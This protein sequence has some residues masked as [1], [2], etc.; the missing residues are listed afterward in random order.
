MSTN[1]HNLKSILSV[2]AI[3]AFFVGAWMAADALAFKRTFSGFW[4]AIYLA[5]LFAAISL[6]LLICSQKRLSIAGAALAVVIAVLNLPTI[7][8]MFP[9]RHTVQPGSFT[10]ATVADVLHHIAES[11][12]DTMPYW[13]FHVSD[14]Q[15]ACTPVNMAIP[16]NASLGE[17]LNT[18]MAQAEATYTWTWHKNYGNESLPLCASFLV[19]RDSSRELADYELTI[20]RYGIY[21][22]E[23]VNK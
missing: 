4:T 12:H 21:G 19:S 1:T 5:I 20:D 9:L 11:K 14:Q 2:A 6:D 17:T 13:R 18:L 8:K 10:N 3:A 23:R 7:P 15:L 22:L 16:S